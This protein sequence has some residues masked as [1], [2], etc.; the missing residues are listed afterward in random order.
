MYQSIDEPGSCSSRVRW[1]GI[2]AGMADM[3]ESIS[4]NCVSTAK[5]VS[6][7]IELFDQKVT[8]RLGLSS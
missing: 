3:F 5:V 7:F 8:L 1:P 6:Y 2:V 4:L